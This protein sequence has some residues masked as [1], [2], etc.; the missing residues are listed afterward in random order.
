MCIRDSRHVA[1]QSR[2]CGRLV[3]TRHG[4]L[5]TLVPPDQVLHAVLGRHRARRA[6]RTGISVEFLV[7][8]PD[9]LE[10]TRDGLYLL[11]V[12]A[13]MAN[14]SVRQRILA[15]IRTEASLQ[16]LDENAYRSANKQERNNET[17]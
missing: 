12:A 4:G 13:V 2:S 3:P 10:A 17:M 6:R 7:R 16:E 14:I 5:H 9:V 11:D 8:S 15:E 1:R